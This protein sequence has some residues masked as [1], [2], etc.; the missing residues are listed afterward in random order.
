VD[1]LGDGDRIVVGQDGPRVRG[2]LHAVVEPTGQQ[3]AGRAQRRDRPVVERHARLVGGPRKALELP[4]C[5]RHVAELEQIADEP[6]ERIERAALVAEL[7]S[8]PDAFGGHR[9]PRIQAV[10]TGEVPRIE[11]AREGRGVSHS[12]GH[13]DGLLAHR[14]ASCGRSGDPVK[15]LRE[16]GEHADAQHAIARI[17]P[18]ERSLQQAELRRVGDPGMRPCFPEPDRRERGRGRIADLLGQL[19][20]FQ[21]LPLG[22]RVVSRAT[23]GIA[24]RQVHPDLERRIRSDQR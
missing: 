19:G 6:G 11:R 20:C 8:D 1:L 24:E 22:A 10:A 9:E 18:R 16:R 23:G 7:A 13:G 3:R 15:C 12:P 5:R 14:L 4:V 21:E 2:Q 17:E